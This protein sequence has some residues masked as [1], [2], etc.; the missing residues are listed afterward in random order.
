MKGIVVKLTRILLTAFFSIFSAV[1]IG[2]ILMG[3]APPLAILVAAL[4]ILTALA[5]NNKGGKIPRYFGYLCGGLLSF[6]FFGAAVLTYSAFVGDKADVLLIIVMA[7]FGFVGASTIYSL[8]HQ[9]QVV[10]E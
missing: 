1:G 5:L 7:I 2:T 10:P 6:C 8:K 3:K 9:N 4:Y